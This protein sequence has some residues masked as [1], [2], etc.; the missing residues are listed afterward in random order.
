MELLRDESYKLV[1]DLVVAQG[2]V[3]QASQ[4]TTKKLKGLITM[5]SEKELEKQEERVNEIII[6]SNQTFQNF[7]VTKIVTKGNQQ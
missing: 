6:N 5:Q 7:L 1:E 4:E 3:K 2:V